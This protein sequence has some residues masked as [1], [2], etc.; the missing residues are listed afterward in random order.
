MLEYILYDLSLFETEDERYWSEKCTLAGLEFL[1][2]CDQRYLAA[3]PDTPLLYKAG[4]EYKLPAQME[5]RNKPV[6]FRGEHFRDIGRILENGG[7]DCDNLACW[8]AAEIRFHLGVAA[9]PY[10]TK[11]ERPGGGTTYHVIVRWP[12]GSSEDPSLLL[13]MGGEKRAAD[14]ANEVR[15]LRERQG[16][17][18]AGEIIRRQNPLLGL[19]RDSQN[20]DELDLTMGKILQGRPY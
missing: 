12:D 5:D 3:H 19:L 15:K 9:E 1:T 8:R 14:R 4:V 20:Q 6:A 18:I 10:I 7:G 13:G 17:E 16:E 2:L 11:K